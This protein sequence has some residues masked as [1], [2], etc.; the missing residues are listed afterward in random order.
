MLVMSKGAISAVQA[1]TYYEEK[2]VQDDYYS[3][4]QRV[5]GEWFGRG[6][7]VLGLSREVASEDFRAVLRGQ[8]PSNEEVLVHIAN[9]RTERRAGWD[10]TFN[11][12]KSV[13]IEALVGGDAELAKAHQRAV[14]RALAEL[15]H[16]ALSRRNGGSEWVSTSNIVAA[17]FDH[18]AAQPSQEI[19]DGYGPDPHLHTHLLIPNITP[20]PHPPCRSLAPLEI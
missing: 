6:A 20:R 1:E 3:E 4:E 2:Y 12:P 7:E 14:S 9:G 11:A 19:A 15:E 8:R 18:I 16:Y 13:S 17:R 10:A 5:V